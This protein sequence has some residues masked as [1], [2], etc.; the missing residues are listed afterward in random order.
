MIHYSIALF[1]TQAPLSY[2][3]ADRGL[4]PHWYNIASVLP[5]VSIMQFRKKEGGGQ[6][7]KDKMCMATESFKNIFS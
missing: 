1:R 7:T 3:S 6:R 4:S 5:Q 2:C